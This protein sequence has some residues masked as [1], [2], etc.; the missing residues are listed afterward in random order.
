MKEAPSPW[1][2]P[3]LGEPPK[4]LPEL[5]EPPKLVET[6]K[7]EDLTPSSSSIPEVF[8]DELP[9]PWAPQEPPAAVV[10]EKSFAERLG[11]KSKPLAKPR[12]KDWIQR[13]GNSIGRFPKKKKRSPRINPNSNLEAIEASLSGDKPRRM[14][15]VCSDCGIEKEDNNFNFRWTPR[16][17]AYRCLECE[18]IA[19]K[20]LTPEQ[21]QKN[22]DF[23]K[24]LRK[25]K[26]EAE[27]TA[28]ALEKSKG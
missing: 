3:E 25:A 2:L 16:G 15:K 20:K 11:E 10:I 13:G 1:E 23:W 28:P 24:R 27:A 26:R 14:T 18:A 4:E 17:S 6:R 7:S 19:M 5:G 9:E 8:L 12:G 21:R 22:R